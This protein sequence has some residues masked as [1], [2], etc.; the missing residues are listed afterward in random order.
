MYFFVQNVRANIPP[1][2]ISHRVYQARPM[3]A[4]PRYTSIYVSQCINV[5]DGVCVCVFGFEYIKCMSVCTQTY[6]QTHTHT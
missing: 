2:R 6:I 1:Y 4:H 5:D 3:G